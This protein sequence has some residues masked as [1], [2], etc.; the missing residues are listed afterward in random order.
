MED[1][2]KYLSGVASLELIPE[3]CT[4]C[5]RCVEVCPHGVFIMEEK[6]ASIA[7]RDR[8]MECGACA[9]NCAFDAIRVKAGVGCAQAI[10]HSMIYGGEPDCGCSGP[11]E[12]TG[13]CC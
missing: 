12:R 2:V 10:I 7:D 9:L 6:K 5:G 11:T 13:G 1:A 8:C 4:G 3:K